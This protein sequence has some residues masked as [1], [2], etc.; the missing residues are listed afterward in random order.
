MN[1][2]TFN[3][4]KYIVGC[5]VLNSEPFQKKTGNREKKGQKSRKRFVLHLI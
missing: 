2:N 5:G 3:F 1:F 4:L